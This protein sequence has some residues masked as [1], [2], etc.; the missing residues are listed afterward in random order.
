MTNFYRLVTRENSAQ[1]L[2]RWAAENRPFVHFDEAKRA[3]KKRAEKSVLF[4]A[5]DSDIVDDEAAA[6]FRRRFSIPYEA[7]SAPVPQFAVT[8]ERHDKLVLV[9]VLT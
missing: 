6:L 7:V 5:A 8:H 4:I 3:I 9:G 2:R 1:H